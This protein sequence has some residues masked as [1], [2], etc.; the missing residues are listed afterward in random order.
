MVPDHDGLTATFIPLGFISGE[1]DPFDVVGVASISLLPI[2][3]GIA[4]FRYRLY[5]IDRI[6]S[7]TLA[8]GLIFVLLVVVF[9]GG[10]LA[11]QAILSGV[12]QGDTLAVAGSTL[13]T[14][15]LFQPV[16]TRTQTIVDRRFNRARIDAQLTAQTLTERLRTR[17]ELAFVTAALVET[18]IDGLAPSH[19]GIWIRRTSP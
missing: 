12:T 1:S 11:L 7:R 2:S 4:I 19:V 17:V 8:G 6:V 3:I 10:L 15:V 9:T 18:A 13:V 14:A 5:E 16:R